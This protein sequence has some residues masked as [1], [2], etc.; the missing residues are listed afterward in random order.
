MRLFLKF[1]CSEVCYIY[2]YGV[3]G[4]CVWGWSRCVSGVYVHTRVMH[5]WWMRI[6]FVLFHLNIMW[7]TPSLNSPSSTFFFLYSYSKTYIIIA[8]CQ[9]RICEKRWAWLFTRTVTWL[10]RC[11][12]ISHDNLKS[13]LQVII[14]DNLTWYAWFAFSGSPVILIPG[15]S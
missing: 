1:V 11:L 7:Q 2:M 12:S 4:G 6:S 5:V 3:W 13:N 8:T 9:P 14:Y 10:H 15:C